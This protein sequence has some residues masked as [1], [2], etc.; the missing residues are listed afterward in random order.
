MSKVLDKT[1]I[2]FFGDNVSSNN[3]ARSESVTDAPRSMTDL[4]R[5]SVF[6]IEALGDPSIPPGLFE[7]CAIV[8]PGVTGTADREDPDDALS[9]KIL[10]TAGT[11][12]RILF[13]LEAAAVR[14]RKNEVDA[15]SSS[16][17]T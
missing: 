1:P 4:G 14:L 2:I 6:P 9:S 15:H 7:D 16:N 13:L 10:D 17:L 11:G 8:R 12:L 3:A 5:R